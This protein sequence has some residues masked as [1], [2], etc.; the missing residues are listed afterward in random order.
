[1]NSYE[2]ML[3]ESQERM[4]VIVNRGRE[5]E[6]EEVFEKW[7]LHAARVGGKGGRSHGCSP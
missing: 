7:D 5:R 6:L 1:M 2:I 3:S 4:L